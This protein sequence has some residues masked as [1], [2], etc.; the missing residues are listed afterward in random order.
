MSE[1]TLNEEAVKYDLVV[2]GAGPAGYIAAIRA[3]ELG[4]KVAVVEKRAQLGGT[5]LNVGCIPSKALLESTHLYASARDAGKDHG[6]TIENIRLDWQKV[7]ARKEKVVKILTLGVA[8]LFKK[9]QIPV[10]YGI[11]RIKTPT[12]VGVHGDTGSTYLDTKKIL[13]ATGSVPIGMP[14]LPFD[15]DSVLDST[16][17]LNLSEI[18]KTLIV[19]GGGAIGLEMASVFSRV[20]SQVTVIEAAERLLPSMDLEL[21]DALE[22]S[23][24]KQGIKFLINHK[25]IDSTVSTDGMSILCENGSGV[26]N[27]L[28]AEKILVSIGRRATVDGL[29]CESIGVKKDSRGR[30]IV[31]EDYQTSIATIYAVGDVIDGPQL[32][33]KA[34]EEAIIAIEKM[35]GHVAQLDYGAIPSVIYTNPEV[36]TV[37]L[38]LEQA[39]IKNI[40]I[41]KSQFSYAANGRAIAA[42]DRE[43]FVTLIACA[44]TGQLLGAN[45]IGAHA[46]ELLPEIV[47]AIRKKLS[48]KDIAQTIHAHPTLAEVIR[49]AGVGLIK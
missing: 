43:G 13:I 36:A 44:T 25:V 18:P 45:L 48:I 29:G 19:V 34:S 38:S 11:G 42:G 1:S 31:N 16:G 41:K 40:H 32:A 9:N 8:S 3:A 15:G 30:V 35:A 21:A 17:L 4:L 33:H 10:F 20:G 37:G 39:K 27:S 5:C 12:R 2:I 47:L 24:K 22:R 23:L 6:F 49:E 26:K 14:L 7:Q 28:A 46:S